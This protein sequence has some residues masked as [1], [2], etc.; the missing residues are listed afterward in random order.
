MHENNGVLDE[1]SGN[2]KK[3]TI[4]RLVYARGLLSSSWM[5]RLIAR[6]FSAHYL[7]KAHFFMVNSND[8]I[9]TEASIDYDMDTWEP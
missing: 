6:A 4:L 1:L 2:F 8:G 9:K 7:L 3:S 5:A